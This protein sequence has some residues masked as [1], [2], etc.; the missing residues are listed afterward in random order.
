MKMHHLEFGV[1]ELR[2][3]RA[4]VVEIESVNRQF[5]GTVPNAIM[6]KYNVVKNLY[7]EQLD[8]EEYLMT[9]VRPKAPEEIFY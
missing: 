8:T 7:A 5:P 6:K 3:L 4:V 9:T 1:Q 2:A